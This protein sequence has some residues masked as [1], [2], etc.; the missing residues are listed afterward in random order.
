LAE[1]RVAERQAKAAS[2]YLSEKGYAADIQVVNDRSNPLQKGSSIVL[3][4]ETDTGAIVGADAI[5]ELRK[6]SEAVGREAA[7][8]LYTE[9]S[10]TPT[11]DAHLADMLIPYMTLTQSASAFL[12]RTVSDH[13]EANIWLAETISGVRFNVEKVNNLYRIE[14]VG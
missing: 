13:L 1:R 12:A 14:K 8:R 9:L 11:V 2:A 4:A 10:V 7:E 6:M 3:W 5:G